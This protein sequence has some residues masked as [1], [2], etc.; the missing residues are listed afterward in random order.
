MAKRPPP[1]SPPCRY[2]YNGVRIHPSDDEIKRME[3]GVSWS[4]IC[5]EKWLISH[6][7]S[8]LFKF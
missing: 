2:I 4:K 1:P 3:N 5:R 6:V 7:L 8:R